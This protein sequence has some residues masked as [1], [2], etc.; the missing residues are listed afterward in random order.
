MYTL[1]KVVDGLYIGN[2]V[3][4]SRKELLQR[5]GITHILAAGYG[6]KQHFPG[7]FVYKQIDAVDMPTYEIHRHFSECISFIDSAISGGGTVLV[8]CYQGVSRSATI[9][10]AYLMHNQHITAP[11]AL[12]FLKEKHFDSDPNFGFVYQLNQYEIVIRN[13]LILN[14]PTVQDEDKVYCKCELF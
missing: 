7:C 14:T 3:A 12:K 5:T 2:E 8:H 9:I 11:E 13:G 1:D 4:S 6:L 10:S